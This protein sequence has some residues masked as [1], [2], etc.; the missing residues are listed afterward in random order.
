[1]PVEAQVDQP[2]PAALVLVGPA[3][4][5]APETALA[6]PRV[7]SREPRDEVAIVN[8]SVTITRWDRGPTRR[9]PVCARRA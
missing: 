2:V 6:A 5:A 3:H 4:P 8:T 9:R 1:V 7:G